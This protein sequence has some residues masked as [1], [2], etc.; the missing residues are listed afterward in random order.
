MKIIGKK[1]FEV[2]FR[3][4]YLPCTSNGGEVSDRIFVLARDVPEVINNLNQDYIKLIS[5]IRTSA[6]GIYESA[7]LDIK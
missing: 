5:D 3:D 6:E 1:L 7:D 4:L 2:R